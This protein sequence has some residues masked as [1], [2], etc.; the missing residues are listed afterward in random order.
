MVQGAIKMSD[1]IYWKDINGLTGGFDVIK[2]GH[3]YYA[4]G[5]LV[6]WHGQEAAEAQRFLNAI[7]HAVE[8]MGI[9]KQNA[10]HDHDQAADQWRE[11]QLGI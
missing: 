3:E 11:R 9:S 8:N 6:Y 1:K 2:R 5:K 10:D 7:A 4:D